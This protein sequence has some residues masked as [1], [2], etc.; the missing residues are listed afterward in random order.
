[1]WKEWR[2]T[3]DKDRSGLRHST[4]IRISA[5]GFRHLESFHLA[6]SPSNHKLS[7]CKKTL[8]AS[9]K[10]MCQQNEIDRVHGPTRKEV[11]T[12]STVSSGGVGILV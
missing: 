1:M 4:L 11:R 2:S 3:N 12:L 6:L 7:A 9:P 10:W 5:F 8:S